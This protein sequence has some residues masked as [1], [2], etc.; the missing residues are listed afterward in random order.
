MKRNLATAVGLVTYGCETL[1]IQES[2][3]KKNKNGYEDKK[4]DGTS[5]LQKFLKKFF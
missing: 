5:L 3:R 1:S 4:S 2:N